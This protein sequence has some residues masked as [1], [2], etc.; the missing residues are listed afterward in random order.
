MKHIQTTMFKALVFTFAFWISQ[1]MTALTIDGIVYQL[2]P[3][4]KTASVVRKNAGNSSLPGWYY[5]GY[6]KI[7][8]EV[9]YND[10]TYTVTTIEEKALGSC[11][12]LTAIK[13]P[14]G[15]KHS[16]QSQA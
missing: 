3:S 5:S 9:V 4:L 2:N 10:V 7:P 14:E 6:I 8:S 1:S 12:E 16:N 15:R 13:I 11:T